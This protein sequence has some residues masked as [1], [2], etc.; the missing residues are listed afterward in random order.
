[1]NGRSYALGRRV[2]ALLRHLAGL[3]ESESATWLEEHC[4]FDRS[5][6]EALAS[7]VSSQRQAGG[8]PTDKTV[9]AEAFPDLNK[10][11][12][13][14]VH[15]LFGLRVNRAWM[16]ALEKVFAA[17]ETTGRIYGYAK[18]D[19][20]HFVFPDRQALNVE[21]L[22]AV[23]EHNVES[24][25]LEAVPS[26][27]LFAISFRHA[28]ERALLLTRGYSRVPI[29]LK[30]VRAEELLKESLP[31][32]RQFPLIEQ[33]F[34]ECLYDRL[35]VAHLKEILGGVASGDIQIEF[36]DL[37]QPSPFAR[38]FLAEF[39]EEKLYESDVL[40]VDVRTG[41]IGLGRELAK[42]VFGDDAAVDAID[43]GVV[44]QERR[45][46]EVGGSTQLR[47]ADG[48]FRLL[49]QRGD[50]SETE[51]VQA[52]GHDALLWLDTLRAQGRVASVQLGGEKRWICRDEVETY[53]AFP[54]NPDAA[55][56]VLRRFAMTRLSFTEVDL[57]WRYGLSLDYARAVVR[58]WA[59]ESFVEPSPDAVRTLVAAG[60]T[61]PAGVPDFTDWPAA[62]MWT[63]RTVLDRL[64]RLSVRKRRRALEP[65][66][67]ERAFRETLRLHGLL[68]PR[69]RAGVDGLR[70]V[71]EELQGIFLP[72]AVWESDIFPMRLTDYRKEYLDLLCASGEVLWIGRKDEGEKEGRVAFFL[73]AAKELYHAILHL[74]RPPAQPALL[75][76]LRRR[77]ASFL[78]SLNVE[79]GVT[80]SEL[81]ERLFDLVWEGHVSNDQFAPLR[82]LQSPARGGRQRR[83]PA[84]A[85]RWYALDSG[86]PDGLD[87]QGTLQDAA[88]KSVLAW[89]RLLLRRHGWLVKSALTEDVPF[90]W[91]TM[92]FALEQME[93]WGLVTR[94]L[95]IHGLPSL[96]FVTRDTAARF[97]QVSQAGAEE[98]ASA[99]KVHL[100]SAVDPANPYG[101]TLPWPEVEGARFARRADHY[102][103]IHNGEW[104]LWIEHGGRRIFSMK[105]ETDEGQLAKLLNETL[106]SL[107]DRRR[108]V[109]IAID[110]W[111][112]KHVFETPVADILRTLG[113]QRDRDRLIVWPLA[114]K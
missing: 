112:G 88:E 97:R 64:L 63:S 106:R 72:P 71:I 46:L 7:F 30:R 14:I 110:R 47:D 87:G 96:Q 51:M 82:A 36:R 10:Q 93:E 59:E 11:I 60:A 34:R 15:S 85:G 8:V 84:A 74:R 65:V 61:G 89:A 9:I 55:A 3:S 108:V 95:F 22:W 77:G 21:A 19:G 86:E 73:A 39:F 37:P 68:T 13:L 94:G 101:L 92:R 91:E 1:M 69:R 53:A 23:T 44:E 103:A 28:A 40:S 48:L 50:L 24:L 80:P 66:N 100:I 32:G 81:L 2:G 33:T 78:A 98:G 31:Y 38:Q 111:N 105:A 12:H 90:D 99:G 83:I 41:L 45:R 16:M 27:P 70:E 6:A 35:D 4:L 5:G 113:A 58:A 56:F 43:S 79:S 25:L 26:T 75:E 62:S 42:E 76:L 102:L 107:M 109:K 67:P 104:K 54:D 20:I 57:C 114:L 49:K 18:D 17:K 29:W 52:M